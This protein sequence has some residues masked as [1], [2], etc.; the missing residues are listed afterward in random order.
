MSKKK[1]LCLLLSLMM[2]L[3]L[4]AGCTKKEDPK[5]TGK[6]Q[7][8]VV[9]NK[10]EEK[11]KEEEPKVEELAKPDEIAITKTYYFGDASDHPTFKENWAKAMEAEY[12]IKFTMTAPPRNNYTEKVN[13][14]ITSGDLKGLVQLFSPDE[15]IK[16]YDDGAIE[17]VS[18]YL[19]DNEVWNSLPE[20]L[21]NMYLVDGKIL[22][23]PTGLTGESFVRAIR[24]DWLDNLG[25]KMPETVQ[26]LYEVSR[27]FTLDDPDGN[28]KKDTV[29]IT[30]SGSWNLQDIFQAFDARLNH[31]GGSSLAWNPNTGVWEDSML[32]PG[33]IEALTYLADMYKE[34]YLDNELFTNGGAGMRE[35]MMSGLYGSTF[36]WY[37]WVDSFEINTQKN[38][39]EAKYAPIMALKGNIDKNINQMTF[40]NA[41]Y[42]LIKGTKQ[43][44]E[45]VNAFVNIFFG[46]VKGHI[47]G[48]Y[49]AIDQSIKF[50]GKEVT[51]LQLEDETYAPAPGIVTNLPGL[52]QLEYPVIRENNPELTETQ[53]ANYAKKMSDYEAAKASGLIYEMTNMHSV[54]YSDTFAMLTADLNRLFQEALVKAITGELTPEQAVQNYRDQMKKIGA[55][56]VLDEANEYLNVK[57]N[58]E[59]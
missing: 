56:Q 58:M 43:P 14:M 49:G 18:E 10:G 4:F 16:A 6:T 50:D 46:D 48:K 33:M 54:P 22:G 41:P 55:Q 1:V 26:D 30:S 31:V 2:L 52:T 42:V 53:N 40:S 11:E 21:R 29:G 8:E 35:K 27:A 12:G 5:D 51:I 36:Y 20:N 57:S 38:V 13:L 25:L 37:D 23:I 45:V 24:K 44:K 3:S 59:Y 28:G 19:K 39:P 47:M 34:G 17:D 7:E 32:K 15:A 9:D